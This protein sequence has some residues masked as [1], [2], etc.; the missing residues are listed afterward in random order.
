MARCN[1]VVRVKLKK[2]TLNPATRPQQSDRDVFPPSLPPLAIIALTG[3]SFGVF[4]WVWALMWGNWIKKVNPASRINTV[5]VV[6]IIPGAL[7]YLN[8]PS[9]LLAT[10]EKDMPEIARLH[11]SIVL[12]GTIAL[13]SL[14]ATGIS[15]FIGQRR[16]S[17]SLSP[18]PESNSNP[19]LQRGD[20]ALDERASDLSD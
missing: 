17:A 5:A 11:V 13:V 15:I 19:T 6:N 18:G 12:W 16:F 10:R 14:I 2:R 4:L 1:K 8:L 7:F 20:P 3:I 9:L